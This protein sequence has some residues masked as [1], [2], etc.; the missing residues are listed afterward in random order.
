MGVGVAV[1]VG[2]AAGVAVGVGVAVG[3]GVAALGCEDAN[4]TATAIATETAP[5]RRVQR[6][7]RRAPPHHI[8]P[9]I[10]L[11]AGVPGDG[12]AASDGAI[13]A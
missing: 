6:S 12:R 8:A 2:V 11:A 5:P 7:F 1:G 4:A 3:G 9:K 13:R 10:L